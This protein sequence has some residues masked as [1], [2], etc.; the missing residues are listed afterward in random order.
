MEGHPAVGVG[1]RWEGH[2]DTA[3]RMTGHREFYTGK[4]TTDRTTG[5]NTG[6][7][8]GIITQLSGPAITPGDYNIQAQDLKK[9]QDKI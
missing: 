9:K 1:A 3:H 2:E 6:S 8:Q 4:P 5:N 7:H